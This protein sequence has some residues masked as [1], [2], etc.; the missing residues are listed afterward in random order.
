MKNWFRAD[1]TAAGAVFAFLFL[2]PALLFSSGIESVTA[3]PD[4]IEIKGGLNSGGGVLLELASPITD[5]AGGLPVARR[6]KSGP[7]RVT[8]PRFDGARDRL[9]SAFMFRAE[10]GNPFEPPERRHVDH[11]A[12][13]SLHRAPYPRVASKKGL[14]VQMIDDALRLGVKHAALNVNLADLVDLGAA[15]DNPRWTMDGRGFSFKRGPVEGLDRSVSALSRAGAVVSLIVLVY[16]NAD[17]A[18]NQIMLHPRYDRSAPNHLSAFNTSTPEGWMW[19]RACMEFLAARYSAEDPGHGLVLN[20]IMGNE[21][22]SHW[23]WSNMGPASMETFADD[24]LEALRAAHAAV[25]KFSSAARVFIS[26]EH[27]WNIRFGAGNPKQSFP[28]RLFLEYLNRRCRE[29]GNFDWNIAFHPYPEN[30]FECRTWNDKSATDS[31]LSDRITF[32]NIDVLCD[33]VRQPDF[34]ID[35]QPRRIILSEQ[36][37]HTA[38]GPDGELRQAAAYCYAYYKCSKLGGIDAFI[39]HRHVDHGAE[40]GLKLGLWTRDEKSPSLCEPLR[41]K[42]IYE[43]FLKADTTEWERAFAFAL[44]VIGITDWRQLDS[45]PGRR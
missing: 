10:G 30:L 31:F 35:G 21:V 38:D 18:V 28:G 27:H 22:N 29:Q 13:I 43:V 12:K 25:R 16:Q 9:Y 33:Y 32:K 11:F 7:F 37:F 3:T 8:I 19:F 36:G 34:L 5:A 17:P 23:W 1:R 24:Y 39:L 20:Y 45:G 40:G 15:P 2:F 26:L 44:P 42:I 14:Q 41:K 6:D 4:S